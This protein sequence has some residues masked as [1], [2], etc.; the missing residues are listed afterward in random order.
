MEHKKLWIR[1]RRISV[2]KQ[3]EENPAELQAK[4]LRVQPSQLKEAIGEEEKTSDSKH[5][6]VE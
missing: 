1:W 4:K 5:T 2:T 6:R 3:L